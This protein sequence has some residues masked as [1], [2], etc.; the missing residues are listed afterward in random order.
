MFSNTKID[1]NMRGRSKITVVVIDLI[2]S[3]MLSLLFK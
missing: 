3:K 2:A 1:M